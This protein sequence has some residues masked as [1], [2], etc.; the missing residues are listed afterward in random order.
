MEHAIWTLTAPAWQWILGTV[1]ALTVWETVVEHWFY[2][3]KHW[4]L[5]KPHKST[6]KR[7]M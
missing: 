2:R 7:E 4:V 5:Q 3:L 1:V 6:K